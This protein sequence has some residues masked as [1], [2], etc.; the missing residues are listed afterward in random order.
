MISDAHED[1]A[2]QV[3]ATAVAAQA[4]VVRFLERLAAQF[5]AVLA[6]TPVVAAN[7][8]AEKTTVI[9]NSPRLAEFDDG[10]P[11]HRDRQAIVAFVGRWRTRE[12][13]ARSWMRSSRCL[14]R[15]RPGSL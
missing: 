10:G 6:A 13:P 9:F 2:L 1:L 11:S 14:P 12:E 8:P 7:Y 4:S 15:W 3:M 5:D